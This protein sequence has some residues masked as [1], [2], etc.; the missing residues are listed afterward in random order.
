VFTT[1]QP[2]IVAIAQPSDAEFQSA[3]AAL[4]RLA[5]AINRNDESR[6]FEFVDRAGPKLR[7][8]ARQGACEHCRFGG[9]GTPLD[10]VP[11]PQLKGRWLTGTT[12]FGFNVGLGQV[13]FHVP[14]RHAQWE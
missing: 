8:V 1:Q 6:R 3:E 14:V 5:S 11:L 4:S 9:D 7:G 13:C 12:R 2:V 10:A